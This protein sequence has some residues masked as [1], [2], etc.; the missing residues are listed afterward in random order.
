MLHHKGQNLKWRNHA[1]VV[2]KG[3][4]NGNSGIVFLNFP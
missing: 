3:S 1:C 2:D 4:S